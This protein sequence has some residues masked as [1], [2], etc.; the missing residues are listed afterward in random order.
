MTRRRNFVIL[1]LCIFRGL[2]GTGGKDEGGDGLD[3]RKKM[4]NGKLALF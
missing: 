1:G 4:V 3:K 2:V